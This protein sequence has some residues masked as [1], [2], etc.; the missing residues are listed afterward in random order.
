MK[1]FV[2]TILTLFTGIIHAQQT[3]NHL[4]NWHFGAFAGMTFNGGA[5][6]NITSGLDAYEATTG[7]SDGDGNVLFYTGAL[8]NN[9][10]G[11]FDASNTVMPNNSM[12]INGSSSCGAT[13]AP[14][15]GSCDKYFVFH[16][17]TPP[18]T[19]DYGLHYSIVDMALPG[20]GTI[21]APLGDLDPTQFNLP[22]FT[23]DT[24]AE[25]VKIVQKGN[26]EN[27][28]VITRSL[29]KDVFY[30]FEVSSAGVNMTPVVSTI[31]STVWPTSNGSPIFSWLCVNS[32]RNIL[33]EA[34]GFG[35]DVHLFNF[36]NTT[37]IVSYAENLIPTGAFGQDV[38]Y[39]IEFSPDGSVVYVNRV[40]PGGT[41]YITSFDI[42]AGIG[43]IA[44]TL[45]DFTIS[46]SG[47]SEYGALV[48]GPDG[49]IYGSRFSN[50][51]LI[52]IN[53]PNNFTTP[54]ISNTGYSP[55]PG[56]SIIGLPNMS[57]YFHPDN[58]IDT[59]AG[60]DRTI[61]SGQ[62]IEIGAIGYDSIWVNYSWEPAAMISGNNNQ[63][64]PV[65]VSL[66]ADQEFITYLVTNCGDTVDVDTTLVTVG[67]GVNASITTNSPICD[68]GSLSLSASPTGLGAG[69]YTWVGPNGPFAGV[70]L[71]N[72]N[73]IPFPNP[74][75]GGWYYLTV[76]DN[77]CT[78]TDSTFVVSNPVY[79]IADTTFICSGDDFTYADGTVSTS[80][81]VP[82]SHISNLL[83]VA[84]CDSTRREYVQISTSTANAGTNGT[85]NICSNGSSTD[86]FT[87][88]G[89][90]AD[91]G[92]SWSP[93]LNSG[94][95]VFDPS[96]DTAGTYVYSVNTCGGGT[97]TAEVVVT[98][99]PGP[100]SG[101]D[102]LLSLCNTATPINL[103]TQLGG[104]PDVGGVWSPTLLSGTGVIDPTIDAAGT[105]TYSV[106]N[107]CGTSANEVIVTILSAPN[108]GGDT[109][110]T[111]CS[112]DAVINLFNIIPNNPDLNGA[113]S[114]G[115]G[116][117]NPTSDNSG[118][119]TYLVSA[120]GCADDSSMITIVNNQIPL[121][122]YSV[123][124]DNCQGGKG[125]I[126]LTI[127]GGTSTYI[128]NWSNGEITE[129]I[130]GLSYGN[131]VVTVTDDNTCSNT[132]TISVLNNEI[133]CHYHI[134]VPNTFTPNGDGENDVL[135]VRGQGVKEIQFL[136]Y[137][138]WGNKVF[139]SNSLNFGWDGFYKNIEQDN[140]VFVYVI[141][142]KFENDQPFEQKGNVT[143]V[144]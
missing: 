103:F 142:G 84:G 28:W 135:Y 118:I 113:W 56:I 44:A 43:N 37:G 125:E 76:N 95:G 29:T 27:Y 111:V 70:G 117:F 65:T 144:K 134:Y 47:S 115:T 59:L 46:T 143:I 15:P 38:P 99:N 61:C 33:A 102:G 32:Q 39:G 3:S 90:A 50:T 96:I 79:N 93:V 54:N 92:G 91:T 75:P 58:Y 80:I 105:Y 133:D 60:N 132:E 137:N 24:L 104:T 126:D 13:T 21:G 36:D 49:K 107:S 2:F 48:R 110:L 9:T 88:L 66:F 42:T 129:D 6:A 131:Y 16:L 108:A 119:Y 121:I 1:I 41:T 55:A 77:G 123:I 51:D 83:T 30:S 7:Y 130:V 63:A 78:G 25:K 10:T 97:I 122:I 31:S 11:I 53:D 64:T 100:N 73:I 72:V 120:T 57:Y 34:N 136:I 45:Q 5:P 8:D 112:N 87:Q 74:I 40:V 124:D 85:L 98:I 71:S 141:K 22:I 109:G 81:T 116:L 19:T 101:I 67:T 17:M 94:S 62:Q 127:S 20:N 128:Y 35:P 23:A 114:N 12:I 69:N 89:G 86:L 26:T 139:E 106:T 82:E 4:N 140:A 68:G 138:R 14:F 18:G 52:V